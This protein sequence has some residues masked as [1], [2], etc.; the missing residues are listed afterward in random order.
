MKG[1]SRDKINNYFQADYSE[2]EALR[3]AMEKKLRGK[4]IVTKEEKQK[5]IAYVYRQGFSISHAQEILKE[6]KED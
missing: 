1:I 3:K 2:E 6:Y 4:K 5:I